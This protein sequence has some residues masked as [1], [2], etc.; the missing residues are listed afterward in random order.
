MSEKHF[1]QF[2]HKNQPYTFELAEF[3]ISTFNDYQ[4][5]KRQGLAKPNNNALRD[6]KATNFSNLLSGHSNFLRPQ[7][8]CRTKQSDAVVLSSRMVFKHFQRVI[9]V[10]R[11]LE[12][13]SGA[14]TGWTPGLHRRFRGERGL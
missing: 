7:F 5:D 10:L 2:C 13:V 11:G 6:I 9:V 1:I 3:K 8:S 12:V 14:G 4:V